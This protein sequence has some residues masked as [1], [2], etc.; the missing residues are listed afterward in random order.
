MKR[1]IFAWLLVGLIALP[2]FFALRGSLV[3]EQHLYRSFFDAPLTLEHYRA[4]FLERNFLRSIWS[5]ILVA[6]S[7][8]LLC[9]AIGSL[10]GYALARLAFRG[11]AAIL[12]LVLAVSMFPQI[13]IVSPLYLLLRTAGLI[14]TVPG[15]VLPYLT[16]ALPLAI[17]SLTTFFRALPIELEEAA[18]VEGAGRLYTLFFIVLPIGAPALATTAVITFVT[19]WNELLFALAFT[20]SPE[21]QT[22]PLAI[23]MFRGQYQV[24]WGE[25]LAASIVATLPVLALTLA[26]QRR[27]VSG[28]AVGSVKG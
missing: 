14:D 19:C 13:A 4:V 11:R 8:T 10:A 2:L 23:A 5:S 25:I 9:L 26:A 21:R 20:V 28:L 15:L 18:Y 7:T 6:G 22:V 12:A 24:P 16:F 3:P 1:G 27:I 17:W